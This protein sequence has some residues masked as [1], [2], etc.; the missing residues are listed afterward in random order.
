LFNKFKMLRRTKSFIFTDQLIS[1]CFIVMLIFTVY[2]HYSWRYK[3]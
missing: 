2:E 3:T 1:F